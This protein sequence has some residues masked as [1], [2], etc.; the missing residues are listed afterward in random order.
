MNE[1]AK[2]RIWT[3]YLTTVVGW[4]FHPGIQKHNATLTIQQCADIA[5]AML[6]QTEERW[7][8][9]QQSDK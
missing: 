2:I 7:P 5:D 1:E 4:Q 9:G 3:L 6:K 8:T